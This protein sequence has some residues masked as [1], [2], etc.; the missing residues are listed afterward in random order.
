MGKLSGLAARVG[1][2]VHVSRRSAGSR[3]AGILATHMAR[4]LARSERLTTFC[5]PDCVA[6][7]GRDEYVCA[8]VMRRLLVALVVLALGLLV[9]ELLLRVFRIPQRPPGTEV[10]DSRWRSGMDFADDTGEFWTP[11]PSAGDEP[12]GGTGLRGSDPGPAG[13][14]DLRIA[15]LGGGSAYGLELGYGATFAARVERALQAELPHARVQ[16]VLAAAPDYSSHQM[17]LAWRRH[18]RDLAPHVVVLHSE[19]WN[20]ATAAVGLP[21]GERGPAA[22]ARPGL[23]LL[24]L[25]ARPPQSTGAPRVSVAAYQANLRAI[26]ADAGA[27][28]IE[29]VAAAAAR[30]PTAIARLPELAQYH[31]AQGALAVAE[32]A[33]VVDLGAFLSG[34]SAIPS[35]GPCPDTGESTAFRDG[36]HLTGSAH[37]VVAQALVPRLRTTRRYRE[38]IA[39]PA[40]G[41]APAF[42][43]FE[44]TQVTSPGSATI[45]LRG[46]GLVAAGMPAR[47]FFGTRPATQVRAVDAETLQA[48]TPSDLT[49]GSHVVEVVTAYGSAR[50]PAPIEVTGVDLTVD[51]RRAQSRIETKA[52][53][54]A[55]PGS[56]VQIWLADAARTQ[57]LPTGAGSFWLRHTTD[58]TSGRA[59]AFCYGTLRL[60]TA[61]ATVGADGTWR[62]DTVL[63]P[64]SL[65][66]GSKAA[67]QGVIWVGDRP[68]HG[69]ATNVVALPIQ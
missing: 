17:L 13:P 12:V 55:P 23:A 46:T 65:M 61:R 8:I 35:D 10:V 59:I 6:A 63:D 18:V 42:A 62:I 16:V 36:V 21:D 49:P 5:I 27:A 39:M 51:L 58:D 14:R 31:A 20:D 28:Q 24:A 40:P 67:V 11:R 4:D 15:I 48:T 43:G 37:D 29:V 53:G 60:P 33:G 41:D 26:Y 66:V 9:S 22:A 50:G 54:T 69:V 64:P 44:P 3:G 45:T 38:L 32:R 25:F 56:T 68:G 47:V 19:P 52:N 30:G 1:F 2:F 34:L 7:T 57:P